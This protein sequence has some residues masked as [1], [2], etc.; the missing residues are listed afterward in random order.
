VVQPS[1]ARYDHTATL[2][3]NGKVLVVGGI[4]SSGS[5]NS[6]ELYD[7]SL[8]T[9]TLTGNLATARDHHTATLL[10]NGKVLVTG[11]QNGT[12]FNAGAEIFDPN[13]NTWS[14][15]GSL[16]TARK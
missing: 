15:A 6:A 11:G 7:P 2:L 9:W 3:P 4:G 10:S 13:T 8:N 14:S 1:V 5:L 16:A 12:V